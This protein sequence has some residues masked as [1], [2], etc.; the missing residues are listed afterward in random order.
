MIYN[1]TFNPFGE[2]VSCSP[3]N[4][5][6]HYRFTGKERDSED[7]LDDFGARYF[8]SSMG[9]WMTPDWSARPTAV[10][11][12]VFG[13]PQSLNLYLYVRNDPVSLADADGHF[14]DS[15]W[16]IFTGAPPLPGPDHA[17]EGTCDESGIGCA[18]PEPHGWCGEVGCYWEANGGAQNQSIGSTAQ[19]QVGSNAWLQS[20]AKGAY[21]CGT[22]K[23]NEFVADTVEQSGRPRPQVPKSGILGWLGFKRDPTAHEWADPNV[24]I[25][26]WSKPGSV[27]GAAPNDV[28]AQEH[29]S[30]GHAGIVVRAMDG[31]LATVSVN[32]TTNPQAWLLRITGDSDLPEGTGKVLT[33]QRLWCATMLAT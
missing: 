17:R 5:S 3:D 8:S 28:I 16:G 30:W 12:A 18:P 22:N 29:G 7:G 31:S 26:G 1:C 9:R 2:Q 11:Y 32:S 27:S 13:D 10:P 15:D 4:P 14:L 20:K 33:T 23:C 21:G 24:N 19:G 6:N 25:P